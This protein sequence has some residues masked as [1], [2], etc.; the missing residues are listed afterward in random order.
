MGSTVEQ[1]SAP[2][3]PPK[4]LSV[5]RRIAIWALIV[6]ASIITLVSILTTW[7]NRQMLDGHS[8]HKASSQV[9]Q[10]RAVQNALAIQ[11]V[12]QLYANVDVSA[13][14]K[15]RL[16]KNLQGL[17]DPVAGALREPS[18]RT[19]Q[20]LLSQQRF[21]TLFVR[22]SDVAHEK[23]VN[24][25]EN[26]TGHGIETGN[27]KV[28]LD[29]THLLK[30]IGTELGLPG[31]ALDRIPPDTGTITLLRSDQLQTA[32]R[33]VRAI[34]VLSVWLFVLVFAL[35]GLA[36]YLAHQNRRRTIAYVGWGLVVVG[37]LTL[38][39]RRLIGNYILNAIADPANRTPAHH[40]WLIET[41]ILGAIGLASVIYGLLLI[42]AA[43]VAGP[44]RAS[45]AVR[46]EIAP[47]LNQ[48][49]DIT[50]GSAAILYLLLILWGP[51]H[52][53]RTWWGIL[54]IG[55]L[56]ALGIYLLRR[57]TL[58]EFPTAGLEPREAS[59]GARMAGAAHKVTGRSAKGEGAEAAAPARSTA[60][61]LA[62]LVDM[63]EKGA[64]TDDEFEQAKKHVLASV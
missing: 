4:H 51:T 8:W 23:L 22:A 41:S 38:I 54:L 62:R 14:L 55:A 45:V 34:R 19:V 61:E 30:E 44:W 3:R 48:R 12:N 60:E 17:A 9:I 21:Q 15:K 29:V 32:Q 57:Q 18:T 64:L 43:V 7:V 11:L 20:F 2:E 36:I 53:L 49:S 28:T 39:A 25:L 24:V 35:Y 13:E 10:D 58:E 40:V 16:P 56:F 31:A 33:G 6:V 50:W 37:V 1:P 46:R 27:G 52:A 63:K 42:L 26:K 59:L 5:G 47:I